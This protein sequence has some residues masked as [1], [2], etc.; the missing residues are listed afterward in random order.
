LIAFTLG[1][2]T[3]HRSR[4]EQAL[5]V[6]ARLEYLAA[7]PAFEDEPRSASRA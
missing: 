2:E 5:G 1:T 7:R 3:E 6:L 4:T